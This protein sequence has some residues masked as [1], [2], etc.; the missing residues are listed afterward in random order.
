MQTARQRFDLGNKL[1]RLL[2]RKRDAEEI[3]ELACQDDD[4]DAEVNPTVTG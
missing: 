2:F 3:L 4:G 1:A